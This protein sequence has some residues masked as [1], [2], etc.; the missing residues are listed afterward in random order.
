MGVIHIKENSDDPKAICGF[1]PPSPQP[2]P[3]WESVAATKGGGNANCR[4]CIDAAKR[5][6]LL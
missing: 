3:W 1:S 4:Q 6:K 5:K 2:V